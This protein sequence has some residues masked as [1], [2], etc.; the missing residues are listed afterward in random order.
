MHKKIYVAAS[1]LLLRIPTW[2]L[3]KFRS[4]SNGTPGCPLEIY[5]RHEELREAIAIASPN[6]YDSL[7]KRASKNLDQETKSVSHYIS[8]MMVRPT[9]FGLFSSVATALWGETT[10]IHFDEQLL[11]KRTRFDMEWIYLLIQKLY[12]D[13]EIFFSLPIRTNPLLQLSGERYQLDYLRHAGKGLPASSLRSIRATRLI[14]LILD[15]AKEGISV[16]QLW[17]KLK[18]SLPILEQEKTL[19]V[20]RELFSQQF[21]LPGLLPSLLTASPFDTLLSHLSLFPGL[22]AVV[23]EI[24]N[25]DELLPGK[26]EEALEKLQDNMAALVSNKSYLQVDTAYD[27]KN[28]EL[29]KNVLGELEKALN[30]LFRIASV[31]NTSSILTTYHS[32]FIEKYGEHRTVPLL[33]LLDEEKGLGPL[34]ENARA[35]QCTHEWEQW[36]NQQWQECLFHKR[37]EWALT[38]EGIE[39]F[40]LSNQNKI[41]PLNAPLSLDLLCKVFADSNENIDL[42]KFLLVLGYI[43]NEGA[44]S[45]G[46]FLDLLGRDVQEKVAQFFKEEEQL[47]AQS[48]F[49]EL[50]Y[51]PTNVRGANVT[52]CPCLRDHRLDIEGSLEQKGAL[53]LEDIY[54]GATSSKFYLTDKES[55]FNLITRTNHLIDLFYAPLPIKFMRYVTRSQYPLIPAFSWGSLQETAIFLPRVRYG[56]TIFSPAQWNINPESYRKE[57]SENSISSFHNWADR[58]DLP[59]SFFMAYKNGDQHL[60][61]DRSN[62]SHVD[63][64]IR[65]LKNGEPLKFIE[66]IEGGWIK[67]SEGHHYCEISVPFVK[68]AD[69]ARKE[70]PI[71]AAP[72]S[73][74]TSQIRDKFPG[75]N[76]LYLKLYMGEDKI[77]EFLIGYLY[78]FIEGFRREGTLKE[79][80]IVRY[81]DPESQL[82]LRIHAQSFEMISKILGALEGQCRLWTHLGWIKDVC[83]AKYEREVERYGGASLIEAAETLFHEDTISSLF[84]IHA[85]LTKQIQ[86]EEVVLYAL[87]IVN[88]LRNFGLSSNQ[89]LSLLNEFTTNAS[90]L[91]GFRQHKN[92]LITLIHAL[93]NDQSEI[94]EIQAMNAAWQLRMEAIQNFCQIGTNLERDRWNSIIKS[95]LHMHC[96]RLGCLGKAET[97]AML[98]ARHALLSILNS[99]YVR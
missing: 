64:I 91:K 44:S 92:Q 70:N 65:N 82:R 93:Q 19:A 17:L 46:R 41:D 95:L 40:L 71:N 10:R 8:R 89:M 14:Q 29:S 50:S 96:N 42:G 30:L 76:W 27:G 58:W 52:I 28:L 21:L 1:F 86:C 60:L 55:R 99:P 48:L 22:E 84:I 81:R 15:Q 34:F 25:Y 3:N 63:E 49:V 2:P 39:P 97:Q 67:G 62:P 11:R 47:E 78:P 35:S 31:Q 45:F 23:E 74:D 90:E 80:F 98:Y 72:Y 18:M 38:D 68:H 57:S 12:Q 61:L 73:A 7:K 26:G 85:F 43:T 32:K 75:S 9:P 53:A 13:D 79:W 56:R 54:V 69:Y 6:L 87:S 77:N 83:V 33:E 51:L 20:I 37:K 66:K 94:P 36:V 16:H 24:K 88:F 4:L 59:N 5:K